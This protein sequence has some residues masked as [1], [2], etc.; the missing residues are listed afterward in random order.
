MAP[1][2]DTTAL[3]WLLGILLRES[4]TNASRTLAQAAAVIEASSSK[5]SNMESGRYYQAP[6]DVR[7]LLEFYAL[8]IHNVEHVVSLI[9]KD[10][11]RGWWHPWRDVIP[12]W[13]RT[14]IGLEGFATA[15]FTYEPLV[16]PALLQTRDYASATTNSPRVRRDD[17][18]RVVRLRQE[19][20]RRLFDE[21]KP[22]EFHAIVEESVLHRPVG[23]RTTL[24]DQLR[25]LLAVAEPPNMGFQVLPTNVGVHAAFTGKFDLLSFDSFQDVVYVELME[26][27]VYL[28]ESEKVRSYKLSAESLRSAALSQRDSFDLVE[29]LVDE[30]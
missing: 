5:V 7:R 2:Q 19:R 16:M 13:L 12:D 15:I 8:D 21:A 18:E 26:S 22:L 10:G 27:A 9:I 11:E 29:S 1:R 30:R 24:Q 17:A 28:P 14:F 3:R 23:D 4:R 25:H 6:S 20:Q